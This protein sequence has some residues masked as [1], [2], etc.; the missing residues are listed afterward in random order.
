MLAFVLNYF[1]VLQGELIKGFVQSLVTT[2]LPRDAIDIIVDFLDIA[3]VTLS[4]PL[5]NKTN[6]NTVTS[7]TVDLAQEVYENVFK[8]TNSYQKQQHSER[9]DTPEFSSLLDVILASYSAAIKERDDAVA[10]LSATMI[11][12]D[13]KIIQKHLVNSE[14]GSMTLQNSDDELQL[15][16]KNL[17][18]E[19]ELR[20]AA[21]TEVQS[22][23]QRLQYERE[24]AVARESE[25]RVELEKYTLMSSRK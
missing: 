25:L 21:E 10:K 8:S 24:L 18:Q 5:P 1:F 11:Q 20:T 22:L 13:N 19:I 2:N 15:L 7:S 14:G 16:C 17:A 4:D 12:M 23:K 6:H 9:G 3:K